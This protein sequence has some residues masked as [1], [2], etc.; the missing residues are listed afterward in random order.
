MR[1][2]T[3]PLELSM[4]VLREAVELV[5]YKR[6]WGRFVGSAALEQFAF[7]R[8]IMTQ[9]AG[10]SSERPAI[11]EIGVGQLAYQTLLFHS[12]GYDI[13]GIDQE[14]PT[15]NLPVRAIP[16]IFRREGT[17][18]AIK[19]IVRHALFDRKWLSEIQKAAPFRLRYDP[20]IVMMDASKM[21]FPSDSFDFIFSNAVFEHIENVE[22]ALR[23]VNRVLR[24]GGIA[25]ILVHLYPSVSGGHNIE[26]ELP[27][28]ERERVAPP[29]DHL[30][31]NRF[32]AHVYLNKKRLAE[33][34]MLFEGLLDVVR[35]EVVTEG[36]SLFTKELRAELLEKGYTE[37]D[38]ITRTITFY[39]RKRV[40][41]TRESCFLIR[42]K[43]GHPK[44]DVT[45]DQADR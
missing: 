44:G 29:W 8:D 15:F 38:L 35:A 30:R 19:S 3:R 5:R 34:K 28:T 41:A 23:E 2:Y 32:P 24:P 36:R 6:Y 14:R 9:Y 40:S 1:T 13:V 20:K 11:L 42:M 31:E 4:S 22:G 25:Y 21:E 27:D 39:C 26:W 45:R 17:H 37:E 10:T 18:R 16:G 43:C 12:A 33:Y 7:Y